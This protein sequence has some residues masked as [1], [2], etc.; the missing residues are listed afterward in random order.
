VQ[1]SA[2]F[3]SIRALIIVFP[4][5][6]VHNFFPGS[7]RERM[8]ADAT[9]NEGNSKCCVEFHIT[10]LLICCCLLFVFGLEHL[11]R[12][13]YFKLK[14]PQERA[15]LLY[16]LSVHRQQ[17]ADDKTA[18][19]EAAKRKATVFSNASTQLTSKLETERECQQNRRI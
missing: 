12:A 13:C 2:R 9:R 16:H 11:G 3:V 10:L 15:A 19:F 1:L 5:S 4:F 8:R 14:E 7:H 17:T 6:S 18:F